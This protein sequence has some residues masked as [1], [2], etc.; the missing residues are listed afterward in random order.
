MHLSVR[1]L[2]ALFVVTLSTACGEPG[3]PDG[4]MTESA[5]PAP[6]SGAAATPAGRSESVGGAETAGRETP[7]APAWREVTSPAG[8][9]LPVVLDTTVGSDTSRVEDP[10]RGHVSKAVTIDGVTAIPEGSAVAGVVTAATRAG[11]VKGTSRLSVRFDSL[12]L[13]GSDEQY[14]IDTSTVARSGATQKKKDALEI[15]APAAGGAIIGGIV[16]GKKGAAIGGAAGGGAGTAVVLT[17]RGKD[18]RLG[19]G[20][21]VTLR[22]TEPLVVRVRG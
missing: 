20:A 17:Q 19:R 9:R 10:V 21:A 16:G 15:A 12:T 1:G 11:K 4:S 13:A 6:E 2:T 18:V 3:T 14:D 5:A 8:T 7:R 22:L